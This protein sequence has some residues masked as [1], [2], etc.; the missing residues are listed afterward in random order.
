MTNIFIRVAPL[1]VVSRGHL[2][3]LICC[4]QLQYAVSDFN[5]LWTIW[6]CCEWF[7]ICC[8]WFV[9]RCERFEFSVSDLTRFE[10]DVSDLNLMWAIC[11]LLWALGFDVTVVG[12]RT[13]LLVRF[14]KH[15]CLSWKK[16]SSMVLD[17]NLIVQQ[18]DPPLFTVYF[19]LA[20]K[21]VG[22]E[23]SPKK[24]TSELT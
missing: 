21:A 1:A 17:G 5:L 10:F 22:K 20:R 9:I 7:E 14:L 15:C 2:A 6:I 13:M 11:N 18:N 24:G 8:E 4:E 16:L 19:L 12:H 23:Y 3:E